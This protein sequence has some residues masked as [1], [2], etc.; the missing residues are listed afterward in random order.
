M[1]PK[2]LSSQAES[3]PLRKASGRRS[4]LLW[5]LFFGYA[6]F[7]IAGWVRM[8]ASI[9]NWYWLDFA[10]VWPGPLYLVLTG[11]LWGVIGLV[12]VI[13]LWLRRP[14]ARLASMVV[15]LV[16]AL[17]FWLD[18]FLLYSY[19][20]VGNNLIFAVG[21]TVL[22]LLYAAFVLSPWDDLRALLKK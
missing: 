9:V 2:F 20:R 14:W 7:S 16:F 22:G 17:T 5:I 6:Y 12:G 21:I 1:E 4:F 11:G 13:W 10:G 3:K 15:A 8:I 18:Q 19:N